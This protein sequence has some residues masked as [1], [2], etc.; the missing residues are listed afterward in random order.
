MWALVQP[1]LSGC[2]AYDECCW[3]DKA[4]AGL[5]L[6]KQNMADHFGVVVDNC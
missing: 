6:T 1:C 3:L 4:L 2:A 5:V